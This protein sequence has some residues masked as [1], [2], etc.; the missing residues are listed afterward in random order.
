MAAA[1]HDRLVAHL[2]ARW[3]LHA[4]KDRDLLRLIEREPQHVDRTVRSARIDETWPG[5]RRRCSRCRLRGVVPIRYG[6]PGGGFGADGDEIIGGCCL[7]AEDP[8]GRCLLC[9]A[10]FHAARSGLSTP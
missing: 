10:P 6:F 3:K 5:D 1:P 9:G 7:T 2:G 4:R 8:S